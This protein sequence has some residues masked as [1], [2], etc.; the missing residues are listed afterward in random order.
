MVDGSQWVGEGRHWARQ[1]RASR[2][3]DGPGAIG[4]L[5]SLLPWPA[6]WK[7]SWHLGLRLHRLALRNFLSLE[8]AWKS[9]PIDIFSSWSYHTSCR[10]GSGSPSR[11]GAPCTSTAHY[12]SRARASSS[13]SPHSRSRARSGKY[14]ISNSGVR[15]L[16]PALVLS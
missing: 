15:G 7:T 3:W 4:R 13:H 5:R 12:S 2:G 8:G 10:R 14:T 1:S 6:I 16:A 9:S 11:P